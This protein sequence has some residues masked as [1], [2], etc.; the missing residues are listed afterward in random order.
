MELH[1]ELIKQYEVEGLEGLLL[2]PR[3]TKTTNASTG[4]VLA[5]VVWNFENKLLL[6]QAERHYAFGET[7]LAVEKYKLAQESSKK[8]RFVHE[9]ALTCELAAAFHEKAG[10]VQFVAELIVRAATCYQ[11]WGAEEKA[12]SLF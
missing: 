12:E 10:N 11:T 3:A 4:D 2:S 7:D 8:H 9:E 5:L 6:L 1:A